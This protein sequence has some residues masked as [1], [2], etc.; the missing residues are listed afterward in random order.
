MRKV[1]ALP[2]NRIGKL[3]SSDLQRLVGADSSRHE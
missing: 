3:R 1:E 2:R